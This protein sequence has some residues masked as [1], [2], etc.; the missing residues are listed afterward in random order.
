MSLQQ[1]IESNIV[2]ARRISGYLLE[3]TFDDGQVR[4]VDFEGFLRGA[5]HPEISRYLDMDRFAS[6][7]IRHGNLVWGDYEMCFPIADLYAGDV[8][9]EVGSSRMVAEQ[10]ACY[11]TGKSSK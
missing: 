9:A 5:A 6:F 1:G 4:A 11:R 8:V 10:G 3:I 7:E 2:S